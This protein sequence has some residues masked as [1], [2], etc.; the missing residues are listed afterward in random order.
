MLDRFWIIEEQDL[1]FDHL[2]N[3]MRPVTL[4]ELIKR[5]VFRNPGDWS[6]EDLFENLSMFEAGDA[7]FARFLEGLVS[8]DVL[9]DENLQETSARST[10]ISSLPELS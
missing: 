3:G 7:R 8:A 6:T 9:L 10:V 5:H 2:L 1:S 4:T